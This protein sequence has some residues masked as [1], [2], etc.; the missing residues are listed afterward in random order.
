MLGKLKNS[1]FL[2]GI[3]P[4]GYW[5]SV[6]IRPQNWSQAQDPKTQPQNPKPNRKFIIQNSKNEF[7]WGE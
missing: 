5:E 7:V 1:Q 4:S 2:I 3:Q 6:T